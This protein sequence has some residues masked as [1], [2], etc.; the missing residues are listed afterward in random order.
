MLINSI[1]FNK[2]K[3][4]YPAIIFAYISTIKFTITYL[5]C[6]AY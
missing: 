3:E 1:N 5:I 4:L 2:L 6:K